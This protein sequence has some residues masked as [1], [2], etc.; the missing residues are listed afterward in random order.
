MPEIKKSTQSLKAAH[1]KKIWMTDLEQ[2]K[3]NT[4]FTEMLGQLEI[5]KKI[6]AHQIQRNIDKLLLPLLR[7]VKAKAVAIEKEYLELLEASIKELAGS[8]GVMGPALNDLTPKEIK[9]CNLIR[10]GLATKEIA[11][12]LD[13]S[14]L[15]IGTHRTRIRKK[16]KI[17]SQKVNLAAHLQRG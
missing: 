16:L 11:K 8:F 17:S 1:Q 13:I 9:I 3:K 6:L 2:E 5:E 15:T 4:V 12:L 10:N 14:V 7:K